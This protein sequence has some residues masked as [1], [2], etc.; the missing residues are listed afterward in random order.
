MGV[1]F[2]NCAY[3]RNIRIFNE[4]QDIF[5]KEDGKAAED[6]ISQ[7]PFDKWVVAHSTHIKRYDEMT[8]NAAEQFNKWIK[9]AKALFIT[10]MINHI[11]SGDSLYTRKYESGY[12]YIF[13]VFCG[14]SFIYCD[15][16]FFFNY[17]GLLV[18]TSI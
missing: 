9:E 5:K 17:Q 18:G 7:V 13:L 10:Y 12:V 3:A 11:R 16:T 14:G 2:K 15:D 6:W 8:S 4:K 1:H